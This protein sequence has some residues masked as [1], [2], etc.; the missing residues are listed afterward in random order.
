M[1]CCHV[2]GTVLSAEDTLVNKV[3]KLYITVNFMF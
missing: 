2:Q 3:N 1:H